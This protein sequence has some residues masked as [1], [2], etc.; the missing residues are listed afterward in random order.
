MKQILL[1]DFRKKK[2]NIKSDFRK[3]LPVVA[4]LF[5]A[6]KGTDMTK[7]IVV[8]QSFAKG[9]KR[10]WWG[11]DLALPSTPPPPSEL[12]SGAVAIDTPGRVATANVVYDIRIVAVVW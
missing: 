2:K 1:A 12:V 7:L 10:N 8:Y 6:V 4:E 5:H 3:I 11:R 9:P